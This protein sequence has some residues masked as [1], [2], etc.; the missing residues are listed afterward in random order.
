MRGWGGGG[1]FTWKLDMKVEKFE[2]LRFLFRSKH[3]L[4]ARYYISDGQ[5]FLENRRQSG[6]SLFKVVSH[7]VER[8]SSHFLNDLNFSG[9][10]DSFLLLKINI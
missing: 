9:I 5:F 3:D 10:Y 1:S 7:F 4:S 2:F 8:L 6:K